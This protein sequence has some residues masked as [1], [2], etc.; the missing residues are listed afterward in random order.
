MT[1]DDVVE[2][3]NLLA[4]ADVVITP[5]ST[6]TLEAAIF[7]RPTLVPVF[8]PYQPERAM[9]YFGEWVLGKHF[10]RIEEGRL[11]PIL[12]EEG[13]YLP[14]I[15]D[16]L[17]NPGRYAAER[18]RLVCDYAH[19]TDGRST[20]RLAELAMSLAEATNP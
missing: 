20:D 7:D 18:Q 4:H 2:V 5:G 11:V 3:A 14:A 15:L 12:R 10:R 17:G 6:I 13:E 19:F 16:A 9:R 1:R 8:H